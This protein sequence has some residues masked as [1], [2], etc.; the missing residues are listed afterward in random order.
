[1]ELTIPSIVKNFAQCACKNILPNLSNLKKRGM[2]GMTREEC[3]NGFATSG[4]VLWGC[5]CAQDIW[6]LV[7]F[8]GVDSNLIF[9]EFMDL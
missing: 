5:R 4:N 9:L 7:P 8:F 2:W 6:E 3:R 1:M